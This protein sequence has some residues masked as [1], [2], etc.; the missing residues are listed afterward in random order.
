M[1]FVGVKALVLVGTELVGVLDFR[2]GV[3]VFCVGSIGGVD[4]GLA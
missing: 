1:D 3:V 4:A 2:D